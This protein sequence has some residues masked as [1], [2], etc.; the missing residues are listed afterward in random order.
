MT[1]ARVSLTSVNDVEADDLEGRAPR[2]PRA[3]HCVSREEREAHEATHT[4]Y[5]AWCPYCVRGRA[6]NTPHQRRGDQD[7]Q[8]GVPRIALDYFFMSNADEAASDNPILVMLDESTG[9]KYAR[10]VGQKGLGRDGDMDW[11][12]KDLSEELKAWGHAGG[13]AGHIIVK[14]DGERAITA[15]REALAR[16]HGGKVIAEGPPRGESQSNGAIEEAGKVVREYT[17]VLKEQ[18]E[19]KA[20]LKIASADVLTT[21]MI[22]WGAMLCSRY[23]VGRDG[24][25]PYERRRG[26][27]C[28]IL[29]CHLVRRSGT[30][31]SGKRRRAKTSWNPNGA[32]AFGLATRV[33]LMS[34][35]SGPRR[36]W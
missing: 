27:R 22:R 21:W 20:K 17:R 25:T 23:A 1:T 3:P 2:V 36:A 18:L 12:V 16:Y 10:V 30:K 13:E 4:P 5:R 6:R 15:V 24:A 28:R 35:W 9:E 11:L 33:S 29:C 31:R 14:T 8:D 32:R 26:R 19:H 7:R 34:T